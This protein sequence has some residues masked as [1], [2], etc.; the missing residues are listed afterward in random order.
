MKILYFLTEVFTDA[1][2]APNSFKV[3]PGPYD[4]CQ[5][6]SPVDA[7]SILFI[8][9]PPPLVPLSN[10]AKFTPMFIELFLGLIGY[11]LSWRVWTPLGKLT[12]GAYLIHGIW[13]ALY[14][15]SQQQPVVM[16]SMTLVSFCCHS[17][18]VVTLN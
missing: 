10:F 3:S 5:I 15:Y 16:S 6:P 17:R 2:N 8:L 14:T 9:S 4:T 1:E 11:I 12:F 13:L 18:T 7:C